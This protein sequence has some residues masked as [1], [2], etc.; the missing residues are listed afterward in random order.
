MVQGRLPAQVGRGVGCVVGV[1]VVMAMCTSA[2]LNQHPAPPGPARGAPKS[3][4]VGVVV[5]SSQEKSDLLATLAGEY[6]QLSVN[7]G[8]DCVDVRVNTL[9]SGNAEAALARGWSAPDGPQPTVWA[10]AATS[11]LGILR[12]DLVTRDITSFLPAEAP[13]L[14]Q[15]PLVLAMPRPMAQALGWPNTPVGWAD[16]LKVAQDP[17]GWG[18]YG[19]PEWGRFRL[20]KTSPAQ[21]T[22][23]LHALV[24]TYYAATGLSADLTASN[25]EDP[26]VADFVRGVEGSVLH[27]G[28]TVSTFFDGLRAADSKGS[29]MSYV[30]AIATEEKQ[31][32]D[33]NAAKPATPLVAVYPKDGTMVADHPYAIL[34]ASWVGAPQRAAAQAF[35]AWLQAPERQKRFLAA[36]FRDSNGHAAPQLGLDDGIVP[37]GPALVLQPP[38]PA[39]LDLVRKSWGDVRKRVRVLLVLDISGSMD[40]ERLTQVKA[41]GIAVM[42]VFSPNDQVGLWAF[43][44]RIYHLEPIEQVG[45]HRAELTRHIELLVA[46]GGTALYRVTKDAVGEVQGSWDPTR[47]N[48][49]VLLTDGQ[50]SDPTNNDLDGL[51]RLLGSQPP[52]TTVPVFTIGYGQG[53]DLETLKRISKASTGRSYNAPD[54][55]HIGSVFADVISNF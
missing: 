14:M 49:V 22:S 46:S 24:A 36:G 28:N 26:K 13:S 43:S 19:H 48:A 5:V 47:I 11:W 32:L 51:L 45:P 33:Y 25:V 21:S 50:N 42:K 52:T 39:V 34:N 18:L 30:S 37:D 54:P 29:A 17:Q 44:D 41:A 53:A 55:A 40:G 27:Y 15:S 1:V 4:C 7:S 3:N 12:Q 16:V 9:A 6:D 20:G 23:G 8:V 38:A 10:P 2:F 31:I 35:L